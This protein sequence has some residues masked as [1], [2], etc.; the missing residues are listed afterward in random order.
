MN[1]RFCGIVEVEVPDPLG[2]FTVLVEYAGSGTPAGFVPLDPCWFAKPSDE[3]AIGR[4][5]W[6][7]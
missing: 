7:I 2:R 6:K 1:T 5:P 4:G 3:A